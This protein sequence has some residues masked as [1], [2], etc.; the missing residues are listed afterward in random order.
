MILVMLLAVGLFFLASIEGMVVRMSLIDFVYLGPFG[1]LALIVAMNVALSYETRKRLW[2]SEQ[3]LRATTEQLRATIEF[4]PNVAVQWYDQSGRILFWNSASETMFGWRKDEAIGK[5]PDQL[6]HTPEEM[7]IFLDICSKVQRTGKPNPPAEYTFRHRDGS[8]RTCIST[9]FGLPN[10]KGK[11]RFV[12]MDVDITEHKRAEARIHHLA[13]QDGLTGLANRRSLQE[14]LAQVLNEVGHSGRQGAMLLIDLDHFKTINDAL[15]HNVGDEVLRAVAH[16]LSGTVGERGF[17]ARLGGDEFVVVMENL[18][19]DEV[20]SAAAAEALARE[21]SASLD[22]PIVLGECVFNV[23][24]SIGVS[25]FQNGKITV[26]DI[27]RQ[28]DMAL[29]RAKNLGRGNIQF[30][31]PSLQAVADQRLRL[32]RGLRTALANNELELYYQPQVTAAG[33]VFGAEALLRWR[34]PEMGVVSPSR[35]IPVAEETGLI[36]S[37]GEWVLR[38]ACDKLAAWSRTETQFCGDLTV[39][40]SP[41][42]FVR[43]DFVQSIRGLIAEQ[44]ITPERLVLEVTESALLYD[45]RETIEKLAA[46]RS[47][48]LKVSLDDFGTG[49]SSLAYLKDLPLDI[50]KIDKAFVDEIGSGPKYPVVDTIITLGRNMNL[51]VIAEGVE[52][53]AQCGLLVNSGCNAFQGYLF[54]RPLP[55]DEFL[56]WLRTETPVPIRTIDLA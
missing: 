19:P 49:Y 30:F 44:G 50:L 20:K 28:A 17:P 43:P 18:P 33:Q 52:T 27:L 47:A 22:A 7:A 53:A 25:L 56:H 5:T 29:Y 11:P 16:R 35:F 37:I 32:E 1:Y 55:E 6:I 45:V 39:N 31:L 15:G 36:H 42:Q 9:V 8:R 13:Y 51:T 3:A 26:P 24:A 41:W 10:V 12:C 4:T 40:L 54:C 21:I 14:H 48:G 46:L 23:G 38:Q 34:H 2:D